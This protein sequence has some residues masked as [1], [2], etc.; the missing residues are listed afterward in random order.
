MLGFQRPHKRRPHD[1][2]KVEFDDVIESVTEYLDW[3][4]SVNQADTGQP[5]AHPTL[6]YRVEMPNGRGPYNS[7]LDGDDHT[8]YDRICGASNDGPLYNERGE[9][10]WDCASL[11]RENNEQ[12][13]ITE[14]AFK[15]AHGHAAYACDSL[16]AIASW[17]PTGA[18]EYLRDNWDARLLVYEVPVGGYLATVGNGEVLF[19]RPAARVVDTLD[20]VTM[21]SVRKD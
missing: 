1:D 19:S 4:G 6:V 14:A 13:G 3:L 5:V 8:I 12:M 10:Q 20:L 16:Q 11:A 15:E 18:R 2:D 17:F 7:G 21:T 9:R